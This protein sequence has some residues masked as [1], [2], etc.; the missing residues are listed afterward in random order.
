MLV[1]LLSNQ[2]YRGKGGKRRREGEREGGDRRGGRG[3][4]RTEHT[5]GQI[6]ELVQFF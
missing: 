4:R 3:I 5:P 6:Q 2:I 1:P